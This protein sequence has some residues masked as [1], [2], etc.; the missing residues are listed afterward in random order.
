MFILESTL[1]RNLTTWLNHPEWGLQ[2]WWRRWK[3]WT[4]LHF[5]SQN[6]LTLFP[7]SKVGGITFLIQTCFSSLDSCL[8]MFT[9]TI[10]T[11]FA[12]KTYIDAILSWYL[13]ST[14]PVRHD[15]PSE[16]LWSPLIPVDFPPSTSHMAHWHPTSVLCSLHFFFFS[17][18]NLYLV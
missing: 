17:A 11:F 1:K 12:N 8:L 2:P 4:Y 10:C 15:F 18:G 6:S 5:G 14:A 3:V 9:H 16:K 7:L 13:Y